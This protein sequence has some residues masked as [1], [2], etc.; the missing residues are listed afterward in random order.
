MLFRAAHSGDSAETVNANSRSRVAAVSH[1][2]VDEQVVRRRTRNNQNKL[3][4]KDVDST[5]AEL[6]SV[7]V[8]TH[9]QNR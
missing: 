6:P 3:S 2:M 1:N 9:S 5:D 4:H 8:M 7:G